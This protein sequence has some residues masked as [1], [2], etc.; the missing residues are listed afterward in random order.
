MT[1]RFLVICNRKIKL[2][3]SCNLRL[4]FYCRSFLCFIVHSSHLTFAANGD[5]CAARITS[6]VLNKQVPFGLHAK[7]NGLQN[8]VTAN[9]QVRIPSHSSFLAVRFF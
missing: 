2:V 8:A 9:I 5:C 3:L 6:P 1:F 4:A 7:D